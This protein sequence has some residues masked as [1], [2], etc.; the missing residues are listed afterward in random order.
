MIIKSPDID[1]LA[2][3]L[4]QEII[5][6]A[7]GLGWNQ[8]TL[9]K[10]ASVPETSISR[11]KRSGRADLTTLEKLARAVGLRLTLV[12]DHDYSEK[13]TKGELF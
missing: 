9:A 13:L 6:R 12:P 4:T 5:L 8:M 1:T 2:A 3:A 11:I 10:R 7:K